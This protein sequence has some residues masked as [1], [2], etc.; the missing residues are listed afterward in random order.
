[1][2]LAVPVLWSTASKLPKMDGINRIKIDEL[3]LAQ[4]ESVGAP[5]E[6]RH[7]LNEPA[8]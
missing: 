8:F 4:I 1:M 7:S 6:C 2:A 3:F 5:I